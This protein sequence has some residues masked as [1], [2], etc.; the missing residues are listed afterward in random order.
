MISAYYICQQLRRSSAVSKAAFNMSNV[1]NF[2]ETIKEARAERTA[3]QQI[4]EP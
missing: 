2:E 1:H 3:V 4:V